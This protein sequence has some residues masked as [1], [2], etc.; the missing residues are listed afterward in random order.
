MGICVNIQWNGTATLIE[1]TNHIKAV[2]PN[3]D[4][5]LM[6]IFKKIILRKEI[7]VKLQSY[8]WNGWWP[9]VSKC[10]YF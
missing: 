6:H 8:Q 9:S 10:K 2:T 1:S 5:E 3:W 7:I 4:N